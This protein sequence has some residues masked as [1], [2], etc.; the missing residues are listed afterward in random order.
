MSPDLAYTLIASFGILFIGFLVYFHNSKSVSNKLLFFI[1]I[2]TVFW[3]FANYFSLHSA[4]QNI[5]FWVRMVLFFA[6]PHVTLFFLFVYNFPSEK[7]KIHKIYLIL[8]LVVMGL[9]MAL[10]VSPYVFSH[11]SVSREGQVSPIPGPM[12]PL[13]ALVVL[14]SL[15]SSLILMLK[16]YSEAKSTEKI[17]WKV[18]LIGFS[19]SYFLLILTNFIF[20]VI[21]NTSYFV[22]FGPLFMIPSVAGM[23][24]AIMKHH[25][26]SVKT[27]ATETLAFVILSISLF[28]VLI[29]ETTLVLIMR[30]NI[31]V[32]LF[33][34][35]IYL[36][37]SVL[38]EVE[39]R[40]RLE[41]LTKELE[42]AN[43]KL[44]ELN[45]IKS[46][47]LSFASHQVKTPMSVVKGFAT[48]IYDGTY[49]QV[50]DKVK[51]TALKIKEAADRMINL[52]N[53]LLDLRKIEEGKMEFKFEN[54][55]VVKMINDVVG[56]L[57]ELARGKQLELFIEKLPDVAMVSADPQKLRQV[58]QNL[59]ENSIKYTDEGWIRVKAGVN[60]KTLEV[61]VSDSGH[62][63]PPDLLPQVF[64]QFIRAGQETKKIEGTGLGLYIAKQIVE[65]HKGT[66][67][68]ESPGL[69]QGSTFTV[70]LP[71]A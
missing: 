1:S 38:R 63:I 32:L 34:F 16:K 43:V 42:G 19:L 15:V 40:E 51:E 36:V 7:L 28:E 20:V 50:S 54:T 14:A 8:I 2:S 11:Y 13:F 69:S 33:I 17:Q 39:Q 30:V 4:T 22:K 68:A 10:V 53:N 35:S 23:A 5:L 41:V 64:E 3:S 59:I 44:K 65:A 12:M 58:F 21:F 57:S 49:G 62:G 52:V 61:A 46:E 31:F 27:I 55:D 37:K 45:K 25:L 70:R 66:I 47:F 26:L 67:S 60:D 56:E 6:V 29:A 24:Y 48:L 71:L 9:T 18:M